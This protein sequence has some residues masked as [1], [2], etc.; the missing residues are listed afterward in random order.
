[1]DRVVVTIH[2]RDSPPLW[3]AWSEVASTGE[4]R[5]TVRATIARDRA[6]IAEFLED[7]PTF[8]PTAFVVFLI[9]WGIALTFGRLALRL[10][11][12][13]PRLEEATR[14]LDRPVSVGLLALPL[15]LFMAMYDN[16]PITLRALVALVTLVPLFRIVAGLMPRSEAGAA[17][18]LA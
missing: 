15:V 11:R 9:A 6:A 2:H 8:F 14:V 5:A 4:V 16:S 3:E 17:H 7:D 18:V 13:D 12:E 10:E 1:A